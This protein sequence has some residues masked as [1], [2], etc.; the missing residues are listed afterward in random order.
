MRAALCLI[1]LLAALTPAAHKKT[2]WPLE[3]EPAITSA[4]ADYRPGHF[5][6]GIDMKTWGRIGIP[7]R[8]E[9]DGFVLRISMATKGYGKALYVQL[10]DG[11]TRV[12]GHLS[13]FS[14]EVEARVRIEQYR[15]ERYAI[16]LYF[17]ENEIPVKQG[18]VIA[19]SGETG[20]GFPHLHYEVRSAGNVPQN[21]LG[22]NFPVR[23][24]RAPVLEALAVSPLASGAVVNGSDEPRTFALSTAGKEGY[25]LAEPLTVYGSVGLALK[26]YD[27][28]NG[29]DNRFG[30][31]TVRLF[32]DDSLV[33]SS[34]RDS[35]R[36]DE[37][38]QVHLENELGFIRTGQG[39]FLKLYIDKGNHLP[40]YGAFKEG[41]GLLAVPG[42]GRFGIRE[43]R[44]AVKISAHDYFGNTAEARF[45]LF[46]IRPPV[47]ERLDQVTEKEGSAFLA[48]VEKGSR[49]VRGLEFAFSENGKAWKAFPGEVLDNGRSYRLPVNAA[50]PAGPLFVRVTA[51]DSIGLRSIPL[52]SR[53][54]LLPAP[55]RA[56]A[57][58]GQTPP[59][60]TLDAKYDVLELRIHADRNVP[61]DPEILV[62]AGNEKVATPLLR[63]NAPGEYVLRFRTTF[64]GERQLGFTL[65]FPGQDNA[66]KVFRREFRVGAFDFS[67]S[68]RINAPD[69]LAFLEAAPGSVFQRTFL[70]LS[71]CPDSLV[72]KKWKEISFQGAAYAVSPAIV[73]Y[74]RPVTVGIKAPLQPHTGLFTSKGNGEWQFLSD[75]YDTKKSYYLGRIKENI[76]FALFKDTV[77]P[78]IVPKTPVENGNIVTADRLLFALSD[79]GAGMDSD[80]NITVKIDGK[81]RL[82]EYDYEQDLTTVPLDSIGSGSHLLQINVKDNLGNESNLDWPFNRR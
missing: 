32:L 45:D 15:Q 51:V 37:T 22:R 78:Q 6:S 12:Y 71:T 73:Y 72:G 2:A 53:R 65:S 43:G 8:S 4:F 26:A 13:E 81:W 7:I 38:Q 11:T 61:A 1:L 66:F 27:Q 30:V 35:F 46:F 28:A 82:N 31:H 63:S 23:D 48:F 58:P 55:L 19:K 59:A 69:S 18:K 3:C 77:P 21:G 10:K 64:L 74:D 5:H 14:P 33:F 36:F 68:V 40:F 25:G 20:V 42:E 76:P 16:Q 41:A 79:K 34:A 50:I 75:D 62:D 24:T 49:A 57:T 29:A 56:S 44:H 80:R 39:T 17:K 54:T 60:M 52:F 47:I 67:N 9:G 70:W